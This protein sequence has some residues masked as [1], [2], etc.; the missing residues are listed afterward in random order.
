M[1]RPA[2]TVLFVDDEERN[3]QSFKTSFRRDF[4]IHLASSAEEGMAILAAHKVHVV[5][6]DQRMP[7]C[8]GVEFLSKVK[9]QYPQAIRMLLT[10]FTD[11][12]AVIDAVNKG[13]IYAY[14]T[15]PWNESDLK[16]RIRQA[17]EVTALREE[18]EKLFVRYQQVFAVSAD[19]IVIVDDTGRILDANPATQK[20]LGLDE[21]A[22]KQTDFKE[23]L[24]DHEGLLRSLRKKRRGKDFI[25]VDLVLRTSDG[26]TLDCLMTATFLGL[27]PG[28]NSMFQAMIKDISD[29]KQ[30]E[31]HLRKLNSDLDKR[32]AVRTRQL[33]DALEDLGSFSYTVAHDLRSPLKNIL[34]LTQHLEDAPDEDR[35]NL[36]GRIQRG[37]QRMIELVDDLLRFAQT[38]DR[39]MKREDF[40]ILPLLEEVVRDVVPDERAGSVSMM[41]GP[42]DRISGDRSMIKV[43]LNNL[44]S[45]AIKFVNKTEQPAIEIGFEQEDERYHLWVRDNGVGFDPEKA[46]QVFGAFKRL[47]RADQFEGSGIGLAIVQRVINKHGGKV[48]AETALGK[49]TCMH[50]TLPVKAQ[51]ENPAP[52]IKVA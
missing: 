18:R 27:T 15:K 49:G 19:P 7:G 9:E 43:V 4:K 24:E 6:S 11:V 33:L 29:R 3:L 26:K 47:H 34:A 16:L 32:V 48:W 35:R 13:S 40:E 22:L 37:A 20:L 30:E 36:S 2:I 25:N 52:F 31:M 1:E 46:D 23:L 51:S 28:G 12:N 21:E 14:A 41:A 17:Y 8:S 39:E 42:E 45:N 10:G 44:L 5:V 50:I 38:N